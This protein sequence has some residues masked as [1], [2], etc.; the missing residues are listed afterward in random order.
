MQIVNQ[1]ARKKGAGSEWRRVLRKQINLV[2]KSSTE[3]YKRIASESVKPDTNIRGSN[4]I[5]KKCAHTNR[6][7][8]NESHF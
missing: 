6:V 8:Q 3:E 5:E 7:L 4:L 1:L 2:E